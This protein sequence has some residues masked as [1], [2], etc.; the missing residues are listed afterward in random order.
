MGLMQ[1]VYETSEREE[2]HTSSV[3]A[4][5]TCHTTKEDYSHVPLNKARTLERITWHVSNHR[6]EI[7]KA[8]KGGGITEERSG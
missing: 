1:C 7:I 6:K 5:N 8:Q 4:S 2:Q 3:R